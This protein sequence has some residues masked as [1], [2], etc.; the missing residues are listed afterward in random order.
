[1]GFWI[2]TD[3]FRADAA[4]LEVAAEPPPES[5]LSALK[6]WQPANKEIAEKYFT[7]LS[8]RSMFG[9]FE[10]TQLAELSSIP[11]VPT[12]DSKMV[13]PSKCYLGKPS[14]PLYGRLFAFVELAESSAH[15]LLACKAKRELTPDDIARSLAR[16]PE[17]FRYLAGGLSQYVPYTLL[18]SRALLKDMQ[19]HA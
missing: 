12:S 7:Y 3:E 16:D 6:R 5:L 4:K 9:H 1:M 14:L 19:V 2:V 11:F 15:F 18:W 10:D 13:E 8:T 17:S